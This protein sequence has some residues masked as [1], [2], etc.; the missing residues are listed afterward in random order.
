MQIY[1][2]IDQVHMKQFHQ[3]EFKHCNQMQ[4]DVSRLGHPE[5]AKDILEKL[6]TDQILH[7][8]SICLEANCTIVQT[9]NID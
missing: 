2:Y 8:M 3:T 7:G 6:P 5:T 9:Q 4:N 1:K